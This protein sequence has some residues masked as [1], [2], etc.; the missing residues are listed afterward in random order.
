MAQNLDVT[1]MPRT[2]VKS[3]QKY[4]LDTTL[5]E[6]SLNQLNLGNGRHRLSLKYYSYFDAGGGF[7]GHLTSKG[8]EF[9]VNNSD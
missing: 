1:N 8:V 2:V 3:R 7:V 5:A 4:R 6:I 9:T